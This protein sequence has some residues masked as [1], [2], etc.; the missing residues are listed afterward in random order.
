MSREVQIV[1]WCDGDHEEATEAEVERVV[2]L[3]GGKAIL[4]DLCEACDNEVFENLVWLMERGVE[5]AK[6]APQRPHKPAFRTREGAW[7]GKDRTDCPEKDI[8]PRTGKPYVA[9]NRKALQSHLKQK[10]DKKLSD[11]DWSA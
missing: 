4:L 10:H 1:S 3:D 11:Y 5:A 7:K 6:V 9:N 8:D 2:S